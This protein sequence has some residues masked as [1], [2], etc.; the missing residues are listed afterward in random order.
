MAEL[1]IPFA[2][3]RGAEQLAQGGPEWLKAARLDA[4]ARFA[5]TP[6]ESSPLFIKHVMT[7]G[8]PLAD[9][10]LT[11]PAAP[12]PRPKPLEG[13]GLAAHAL[14]NDGEVTG[15]HLSK[16]AASKGVVFT[17]LSAALE[18][19]AALAAELMVAKGTD[20]RDKFFQLTRALFRDGVLLDIPAGVHLEGPVKVDI[21]QHAPKVASFARVIVRLGKGASAEVLE[22]HASHGSGPAV[23]G[24]GC[25][26]ALGH[27]AS[28]SYSAV[29]NFG[30][31]VGVFVNR[32]ASLGERAS[33]RWSLGNFGGSL[34]KSFTHTALEGNDS[35]VKHTEV[36][37]GAQ[38]QRF[39]VSSFVTH[40]GHRARSD[41][42]ARA[43]LRHKSRGNMKGMITIDN[44]GV[45]ADSYLGQFSLLLDPEA[46]SVAI[47][48]LEIN[49]SQV[50]RAKHAAAVQ[51]VDEN[52][53]F[54]LESRGIPGQTAR[55]LI[56]EGFL[57][58]VIAGI[59][60]EEMRAEVHRLIQAKWD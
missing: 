10:E 36:V 16:E 8:A 21:G 18:T 58:P 53:V 42:L 43:A 60:S 26:V 44:R 11:A 23:A 15:L 3:P 28:L 6:V 57:H 32:Q 2:K 35:S 48:G 38:A 9:V 29:G 7:D 56:V 51:Q 31:Q 19:H 1:V 37:F 27:D 34:T 5:A 46:K 22:A 47:P 14:L 24:V 33:M 4:L 13:A 45:N 52:Q 17:S 39:D 41:V 20:Q 55:R 54:Y 59:S 49:T 30:P 25:E 50:I 12:A 40:L